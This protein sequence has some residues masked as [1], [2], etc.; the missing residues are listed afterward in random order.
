MWGSVGL[1]MGPEIAVLA[2]LG[3]T[4]G[5][6]TSKGLLVGVDAPVDLEGV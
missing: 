3:P 2:E 5:E 4:L 6:G 1:K